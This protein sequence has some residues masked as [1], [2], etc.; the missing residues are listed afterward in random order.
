MRTAGSRIAIAA[1]VGTIAGG[2]AAAFV[3]WQAAEL[4]GWIVGATLFVASLWATVGSLDADGTRRVA[5]RQDPSIPAA[6][7]VMIAAESPMRHKSLRS[8][9]YRGARDLGN[10]QAAERGPT[11][12]SK[13]VV[14]R[15]VLRSTNGTVQRGLRKLRLWG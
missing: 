10:L 4:I 7:I 9:L 2:A 8:Q 12:F 15:K 5:I 14:G 11:A 13:R 6:K 3:T 1:I